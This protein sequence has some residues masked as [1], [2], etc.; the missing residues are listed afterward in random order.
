MDTAHQPEVWVGQHV[1]QEQGGER[2][3][4]VTA[5]AGSTCG[6]SSMKIKSVKAVFMETRC[7][8]MNWTL[9]VSRR[10]HQ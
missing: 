3:Y 1:P 10:T 2:T 7:Q 9:Y 4:L 6:E 8:G 5:T